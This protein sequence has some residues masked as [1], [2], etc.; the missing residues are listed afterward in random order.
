MSEGP[1]ATE[2][3]ADSAGSKPS[4]AK[5]GKLGAKAIAAIVI[6]VVIL[7]AAPLTYLVMTSDY[8]EIFHVQVVGKTG[9]TQLDLTDL[10]GMTYFE[11]VSSYQNSFGNWRGNGTY[12][13]VLL[14][15]IADLVGGMVAGDVMTITADDGYW[16]NYSYYQVYADLNYA[17]IQGDIILA[18]KF[19][20]TSAPDWEDG[21]MVAV[22]SPDGAFSNMDFNATADRDP[23][24]SRA[25]SAGSLWTRLVSK[26]T[27]SPLYT[28]WAVTLGDLEG[29]E[30]ELTR[31]EYVTLDYWF[32][33]SYVDAKLRNWSGAPLTAVLGLI[34]DDDP[35]S[36]NASLAASNYSVEVSA[37]DGYS[38]VMSIE[39]L[40]AD[41]CILA[42]KLNGTALEEDDY[43]LKLVGPALL[44][45]QRIS[46]V[47][48]ITMIPLQETVLTVQCDDT[49]LD[50]TM[51]DVKG[52][53]AMT[54]YGGFIKT[55]GAVIGP[56]EYTGVKLTDLVAL[57][58]SAE[59]YSVE[60]TATDGYSMVYSYSQVHDGTFAFYDTNGVLQGTGN[61]VMIV[62][63]EQ[64][65][66]PLFDMD[67]RIAIVDDS[68]P[69]TDG[70]F[71]SKYVRNI[72]IL[73]VVREYSL[74]LSGLWN[75][76]MDRQTFEA[77]ASCEYHNA[78]YAFVNATGTHV[79][80]GVAL[81]VLVSAVDGAD[82][83]DAEYQ[84]NDLL[85]QAG[86]NVTVRALDSY[87]KAFTSI[88]VARNDTLVVANKLDGDP[89]P[90][91]EFPL[92]LVGVGLT[93]GQKVSAIANITLTD[94]HETED[95]TVWLNGTRDVQMSAAAFAAIYYCG[96][97]GPYFNYTDYGGWHTA[98][99]D[100]TNATGDH[101]Y[102][103]I[104]L[105]ALISCVDGEDLHHYEFNE[106]LA[107]DGYTVKIS[108]SDGYN[109]TLTSAEI[110]YNNSLVIAF[111]LDGE[112]LPGTMYP[113]RLV[114]EWL[115]GSMKVSMIVSIEL[116]G[117]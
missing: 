60:V 63:Y 44:S 116:V 64:D 25:T 58:S 73:P 69:I 51:Y 50:F 12:G 77:L 59:D 83:P 85:A 53:S 109:V 67:L 2:A 10:E 80:S 79:Y 27:I 49:I 110:A 38:K 23:E 100:Y 103:G 68:A 111:M 31:T 114:S 75:M 54:S 82:G 94:I 101:C 35:T 56:N 17:D 6:V 24:Y 97:H 45:T 37:A 29:S 107:S 112:P 78:E 115:S 11:A 16:Q 3:S 28:E 21:P 87:S 74:N 36:Y 26:I 9:E 113:L 117:V 61:F 14:S 84:F 66:L 96:L 30:T 70:H 20:G 72:T 7:I 62:A 5:G 105:W 1:G 65:G 106:T 13:G 18:Y 22:L 46:Q 95:W 19:N 41:V 98:H 40:T 76:T 99:Y 48:S 47:A 81:W 8:G 34:D 102:A 55:T 52:L 15:E 88:K 32:G 57:V 104:P 43:P 71:W 86:Y 33:E 89:L 92:R 108:A 93:S 39:C 91:D 90:D 42:D 4:A